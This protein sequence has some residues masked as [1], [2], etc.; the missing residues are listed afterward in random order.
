MSGSENDGP[1]PPRSLREGDDDARSGSEGGAEEGADG[2][3][4]ARKEKG[5]ASKPT[6]VWEVV[7]DTRGPVEDVEFPGREFQARGRGWW[8]QELGRTV[9][10]RPEDAG[11]PLI[12]VGF[13]R[14]TD[15]GA[16]D[17]EQAWEREAW[18]HGPSLEALSHG[19]LVELL[20]EAGPFRP[21]PEEP[22]PFF[23]PR[24]RK[25]RS[26]GRRGRR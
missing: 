3:A 21:I 9:S 12:L 18:I 24:G 8:A 2:Q 7:A 17:E 1:R 20:E 15:G 19:E 23:G 14:Q 13:R 5:G 10:G 25:G 22:R 6:P 4:G 11:V 16:S 26:G